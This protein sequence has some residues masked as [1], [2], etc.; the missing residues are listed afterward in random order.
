M[1]WMNNGGIPVVK[2]MMQPLK[3][4]LVS[5]LSQPRTLVQ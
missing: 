1:V 4:D 2:L 3:A 5:L